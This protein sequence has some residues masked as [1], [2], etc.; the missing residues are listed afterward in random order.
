MNGL[1]SSPSA[2]G[3]H[4]L[5]HSRHSVQP[6]MSSQKRNL[7]VPLIGPAARGGSL[8]NGAVHDVRK[9]TFSG[10]S[11]GSTS[12]GGGPPTS[13]KLSFASPSDG[14]IKNEPNRMAFDASRSS[15][16]YAGSGN[17]FSNGTQ[18]LAAGLR[19]SWNAE[20]PLMF[21]GSGH[22]DRA[23][24]APLQGNGLNINQLSMLAASSGLMTTM[25]NG[26]QNQMAPAPVVSS[27]SE[28]MTVFNLGSDTN[29]ALAP[30]DYSALASASSIKPVLPNIQID[31]FEIQTQMLDGGGGRSGNLPEGNGTFDQQVVGELMGTSE[32]HS[33]MSGG[34]DLDDLVTAW[35]NRVSSFL[36]SSLPIHKGL[37]VSHFYCTDLLFRFYCNPFPNLKACV[38]VISH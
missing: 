21:P 8:L 19:N 4:R 2:H 36:I 26:F 10:N 13:G 25:G 35:L 32:A 30:I 37:T 22:N 24:G 11:H 33:Q 14:Y 28:Q 3:M 17:S 1:D 7:G 38:K 29:S 5:L 34:G 15:P 20:A 31:S 27:D 6:M 18:P 16:Y 12:N 9:F 23:S